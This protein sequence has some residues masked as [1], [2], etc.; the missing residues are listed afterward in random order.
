MQH[1]GSSFHS[2]TLFTRLLFNITNSL[3]IC[4]KI[5]KKIIK[6]FPLFN[7]PKKNNIFFPLFFFFITFFPS[8]EEDSKRE[9]RKETLQNFYI[10]I[11]M[12]NTK[13]HPTNPKERQSRQRIQTLL[14]SIESKAKAQAGKQQQSRGRQA[15]RHAG[16][17]WLVGCLDGVLFCLSVLLVGW[18]VCRCRHRRSFHVELSWVE[19]IMKMVWVYFSDCCSYLASNDF[20]SSSWRPN[21]Q[22]HRSK[23]G[24]S[25]CLS[26]IVLGHFLYTF[27]YLLNVIDHPQQ[28]IDID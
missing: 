23:F 2:R 8:W 5:L 19:K 27:T 15:G 28:I 24:C 21:N 16:R 11:Y 25:N 9:R 10:Y 7:F 18:L 1:A 26:I 14:K 13:T 4:I 6:S 3:E 12:W 17:S 20:S 22:L